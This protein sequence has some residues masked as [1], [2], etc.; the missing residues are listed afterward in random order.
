MEVLSY[1]RG[2][3]RSVSV[4]P[5]DNVVDEMKK[6]NVADSDP[7]YLNEND[8]ERWCELTGDSRS[9]LYDR[10]A[11]YLARGFHNAELDFE[12]CDAIVND[13]FGIIISTPEGP[14]DLF[15]EVYNAFDAGEFTHAGNRD[16]NPVEVY[17]RPTI[18]EIVER[19]SSDSP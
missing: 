2:V 3:V 9:A 10:I 19:L 15:Y 16:E 8:M 7:T 5:F 17:T 13:M 11:L 12:F 14:P 4:T 6:L 18:R 1:L